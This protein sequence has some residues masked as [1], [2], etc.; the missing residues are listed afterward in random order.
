MHPVKM[1]GHQPG[2]VA[3]DR[4]DAVPLQRRL[5]GQRVL[6]Q[7]GDFLHRFLN[8]VLAKSGLAGRP[9]GLHRLRAEGFGHGQ[10]ADRTRVAARGLASREDAGVNLLQSGWNHRHNWL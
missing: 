2:L 1:L 6:A 8:I 3:L 5:A 9:G 10:Q 7:R 4:T